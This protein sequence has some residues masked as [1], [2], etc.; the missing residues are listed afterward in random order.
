MQVVPI[1]PHNGWQLEGMWHG[2]RVF[3]RSFPSLSPSDPS[4][5]LHESTTPVMAASLIINYPT[6]VK[7]L[8]FRGGKERRK[9]KCFMAL[10]TNINLVCHVVYVDV[11]RDVRERER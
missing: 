2:L 1:H 3:S 11:A 10:F 6:K 5:A 8:E 7:S 4:S 9:F